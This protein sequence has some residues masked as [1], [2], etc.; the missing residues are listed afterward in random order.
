[1]ELPMSANDI[2]LVRS[3]SKD[4]V[5]RRI[6]EERDDCVLICLEEQF[7]LWR[8]KGIRPLLVKCPKTRI[9][10]Y[11]E[12]L[13]GKLKYAAYSSGDDKLLDALW[14]QA[15]TYYRHDK[16]DVEVNSNAT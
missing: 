4:P 3:F 11:D 8:D 5:V 12:L 15:Q 7:I 14:D 13:Y 1:M 6:F 9:F 2:A 16:L 10:H